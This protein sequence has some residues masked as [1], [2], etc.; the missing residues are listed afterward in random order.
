M[1]EVYHYNSDGYYTGASKAA[2]DPIDKRPIV[3]AYATLTAPPAAT[4][5]KI[6]KWDEKNSS[7]QRQPITA[8]DATG[9]QPQD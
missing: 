7:G 6:A 2:F 4:K 3:P 9:R 1:T 5:N 8:A